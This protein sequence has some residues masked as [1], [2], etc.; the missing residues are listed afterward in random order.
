MND[1]YH[2]NKRQSNTDSFALEPI[3]R[4][5]KYEIPDKKEFQLIDSS[6]NNL[7]FVNEGEV[8]VRYNEFKPVHIKKGEFFLIPQAAEYAIHTLSDTKLD[9]FAFDSIKDIYNKDDFRIYSL[10]AFQKTFVFMPLPIRKILDDFLNL[11]LDYIH[12]GL[13]S[14]YLYKIKIRE[15]F[16][17][18]KVLYSKEEIENLFHPLFSKSF[19]FKNRVI[20]YSTQVNNINELARKIGMGR[21]NFDKKF[22][23][24]FG[25]SPLQWLLKE[26]AKH[27]YFSLSEPEYTL[28]D[29]MEKYNF[30]SPTHLNRFCKQQFGASPSELRK[31]IISNG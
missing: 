18:L 14:P 11:L 30:N 22:K 5:E 24:E 6:F 7:I 28:S 20:Q 23:T 16:L 4:F 12:E 31:K 21:A 1:L 3:I 29:I 27:V 10:T 19:I 13:A 8:S 26:K 25:I 2:I 15:L 17:L 9:I